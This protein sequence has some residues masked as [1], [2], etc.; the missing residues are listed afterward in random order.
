MCSTKK[1]ERGEG[2]SGLSAGRNRGLRSREQQSI[3][4]MRQEM[5]RGEAAVV[6]I[7]LERRLVDWII[8]G[9]TI[10]LWSVCRHRDENM[11]NREDNMEREQGWGKHRHKC[12]VGKFLASRG[13]R[14]CQDINLH[15]WPSRGSWGS[16]RSAIL[17]QVGNVT[18]NWIVGRNVIV[19][20]L[21][22]VAGGWWTC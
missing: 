22:F 2:E 4:V 21:V 16:R 20:S 9:G 19:G 8:G 3:A 12:V 18:A 10:C 7:I 5:E 1:R 13:S 14:K 6:P 15:Q 17:R 11:D